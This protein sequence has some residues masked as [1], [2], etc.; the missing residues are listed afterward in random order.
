MAWGKTIKTTP[1][2][3]AIKDFKLYTMAGTTLW[4]KLNLV[5]IGTPMGM[6]DNNYFYTDEAGWK[7]ILGDLVQSGALWKT[8]RYDCDK[9]SMKARV[10]AYERYGLNT[11]GFVIGDIPQGRHSFNLIV[12]TTGFL[13]FEPQNNIANFGVFPLDGRSYHADVVLI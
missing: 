11:C 12:T 4:A 7:L 2:P 6:L 3:I 5:G 13:L 9:F 1:V 8:D 10:I